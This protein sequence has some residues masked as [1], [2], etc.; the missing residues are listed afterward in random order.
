MEIHGPGGAN[1][2]I[3]LLKV[4]MKRSVPA[5]LAALILVCASGC[6]VVAP[7]Y[8]AS[9]DNVETLKKAG[10]FKAKVGNF[11]SPAA[12]G[13]ANPISLRGNSMASPNENSYGAYIAEAIKQELAMAQKL[14]P[15]ADIELSGLLL[16]NDIDAGVGTGASNIELQVV[17]KKNGKVGYDQTKSA[18][19]KWESP[20]VGAV[21]L[22]RAVQE[23]LL[24]IQNLLGS[25]YED[26]D[27]INAVK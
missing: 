2:D 8:S 9:I 15:N 11:A 18:S 1:T 23:Y 4:F 6:S 7:N 19:R 27:F 14:A 26:K 25:F 20:F 3:L 16:K 12:P 10:D 17:V 24:T 5:L 13:N 22:P 21:A